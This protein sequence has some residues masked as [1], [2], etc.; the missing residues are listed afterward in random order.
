MPI[1][2][3]KRCSKKGRPNKETV[4]YFDAKD[5]AEAFEAFRAGQYFLAYPQHTS[6]LANEVNEAP[7]DV[8]VVLA[9]KVIENYKVPSP[10]KK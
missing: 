7:E 9:Y 5:E 10:P 6:F 3:M 4:V 8:R 2:A 1:F